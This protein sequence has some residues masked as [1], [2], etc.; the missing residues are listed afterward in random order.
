MLFTY[1]TPVAAPI[2]PASLT[3]LWAWYD[4]S[5]TS[6]ITQVGGS[7]SQ[8]NDKSGNSYNMTQGTGANQPQTGST[9]NG[10]NAISFDG[11]NDT[12]ANVSAG[13]INNGSNTFLIV[14]KASSTSG[15]QMITYGDNGGV[16]R[17]QERSV[18][19]VW[20]SHGGGA[21]LG[22]A[23]RDT[24]AHIWVTRRNGTTLEVW[25]DGTLIGTNTSASSFISANLRISGYTSGG[26]EAFNGLIAEYATWSTNHTNSDI[27][28]IANAEATKW[29]TTWTN[30]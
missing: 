10:L 7:V 29:G 21:A 4:A 26:S 16:F 13:A 14:T 12:M 20:A 15:N 11:S 19:D 28:L 24:N 8:W 30:I 18:T 9:L 22:S 17:L 1:V 3:N 6:T 27:N 23:T 5:D 25:K 2:T